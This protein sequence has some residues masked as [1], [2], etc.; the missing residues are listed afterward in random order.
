MLVGHAEINTATDTQAHVGITP[1]IGAGS[2]DIQAL[3][4]NNN[5]VDLVTGSVG[6]SLSGAGVKA[7]T[8][9]RSKAKAV[10]AGGSS[11]TKNVTLTGSLGANDGRSGGFV[12]KSENI[13]EFTFFSQNYLYFKNSSKGKNWSSNMPQAQQLLLSKKDAPTKF[14]F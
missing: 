4:H 6:L 14:N 7:K 9:D 8:S 2:L 3:S 10:L 11:A 5:F 13:A 1:N 12:L